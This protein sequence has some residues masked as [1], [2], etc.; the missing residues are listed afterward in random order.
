[1]NWVDYTLSNIVGGVSP[2]GT[3]LLVLFLKD[4]QNILNIKTPNVS[5]NKCLQD[6]YNQLTKHQT[7]SQRM[8]QSK[9]KLLVKRE[10]IQ[11]E[12]GSQIHVTNDN[13]T[14]KYA[15]TL[16]KRFKALNK[17]FKLTDLFEVYP[18]EEV[19]KEDKKDDKSNV[20]RNSKK[21]N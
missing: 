17:E 3:K 20:S 6:Y 18:K 12:F 14:D 7:K 2:D 21:A 5:C 1:M 19:V 11:L 8:E 10:G 16:I 13:I 15:E 9:Y 4:V